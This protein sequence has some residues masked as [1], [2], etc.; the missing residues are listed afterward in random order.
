MKKNAD[1]NSRG[2]YSN[3]GNRPV[4]I[5]S[6]NRKPSKKSKKS[7]KKKNNGSAVPVIILVILLLVGAAGFY[8]YKTGFF[9]PKYEINVNGEIVKVS[10]NELRTRLTTDNFVDGIIIDGVDVSGMSRDQAIQVLIANQ[11]PMPTLNIALAVDGTQY[12]LDL[13][14]LTLTYNLEEVVDEALAYL[15][16]TGTEDPEMMISIY[17]QREAIK[18]NPVNYNTAYT[19]STDGISSIVY[20]VL[21]GISTEAQDAVFTGFN[22]ETCQFE[23]TPS[24]T[25]YQVDF[26][27]AVADVDNLLSSGTYTGV[28]DVAAS[29][30]VPSFTTEMIQNNF[31]LVATSSSTTTTNN[32]RNHNIRITCE[33]INGLFLMPGE[34]FSFN[35]FI[36]ERTAASGYE[37]AGVIENGQSAQ[38][39]GGG[40]C[41]V[42]SMI[43]Q[44]V[45]KSD[46]EVVARHVHMWPST[47]AEAGTDA[48]VDWPDQDFSF[49][50]NTD[51]PVAVTAYW[52]LDTRV[53]TVNIYGRYLPDGQYIEFD[54]ETTATRQATTN[55][56]PNAS[57]PVGQRNQIRP[58]HNGVTA[59]GYQ[60]WMDANGNEIRR[61][62]LPVSYYST[63]NEQIE[64]GV[65]NPDGS[66]A[67]LDT[68]T[69]ELTGV[70]EAP[71]AD[72]NAPPAD[73]NA[74]PADP[75]AQP[76]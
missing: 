71:P 34:T 53:I 1:Y 30:V 74:Q 18:T 54:G 76:A 60:I 23:Y 38:A 10:E 51:Y 52:D 13:S 56:I 62:E 48:A 44:S 63:I 69:G 50:N 24:V 6:S 7:S 55:Y 68:E 64:V 25:G 5:S 40:I 21:G 65:L 47:Y 19:L 15:K 75:N 39:Y 67:V 37:V 12:P 4:R 26:E 3:A 45:I 70:V 16:L 11:P 46:L 57:L 61:V 17:N 22:P 33:K 59:Y 27:Q 28:V 49:R 66:N 73:P 14:S 9:A 2:A 29:T 36:G 20:S 32:S 58:A 31:G 42:S 43:Y 72:P 8:A 35:G 41:Q